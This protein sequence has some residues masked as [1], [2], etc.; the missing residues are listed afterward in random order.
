MENIEKAA[1][2]NAITFQIGIAQ[3]ILMPVVNVLNMW[4][5]FYAIYLVLPCV[6]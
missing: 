1:K 3:M 4:R 6:Y 2:D 5:F